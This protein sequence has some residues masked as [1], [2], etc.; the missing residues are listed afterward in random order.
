[1]EITPGTQAWYAQVQ[2]EI[3]E[4][5]RPIIDPHHHLWDDWKSRNFADYL[6]ADLWNDTQSGHK[7]VKTVFIECSTN[8][9]D[10][11]PDH[12]KSLGETEFA[13]QIA[14]QSAAAGP[15]KAV[16]SGIVSHVDLRRKD[17]LEETLDMHAAAGQ[18]LLRGIRHAG[19]YYPQPEE[20]A[21]P[22]RFGPG[23]FLDETFQAG[24]RLLGRRG[25]TYESYHFHTQLRDFTRLARAAPD[26]TIILDHFGTP[27][28]TGPFRNQREEIFQQW[29]T[30]IRELA[31]CPNVSAKLGGLAQLVNGFGWHEAAKPPTSDEMVAAQKRY[32]LHTIE[33]FGPE[34]CMF[35]SNFPVDKVSVSYPVLWNAFKKMSADFSEDEKA[36]LFYGTA[37]RVYHL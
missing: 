16:I 5:E 14:L 29:K 22:G 1:M 18:G 6:L 34:R 35:E 17:V 32:Y 28:G 23:L 21:S 2:E 26:T 8:Y 9:R 36:M 15:N 24:V 37:A 11:G 12:L 25:L 20:G 33:C 13:T 31:G 10:T 4:P 19:A 27:I 3:L 7:I 30:D